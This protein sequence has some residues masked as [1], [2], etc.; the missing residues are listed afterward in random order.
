MVQWFSQPVFVSSTFADMQ[1]ER[2]HM[3]THVLPALE[4]R[5]Q[6]QRR[7]VEWVD[8]RLGVA[9]ASLAEGEAREMHVL[10]VC[11]AEVRRC[12]PF[13]IVLLGDRYGWVPPEDRMMAA[14][15]EEGFGED[16]LG[17]SVTDLEIQFGILDDPVQQPRSFVYLREPLAYGTMPPATAALYSE[18]Y[19]DDDGAADRAHRL[20]CLK[21][22]I[23]TQMP[24]R[25]RRYQANWDNEAG[26]VTGL[27]AWGRMV[28]D[29]IVAELEKDAAGTETED[30]LTWQD[31]ERIAR[32][33]FIADRARNF[34][35]RDALLADLEAHAFSPVDEEAG[36]G[37][38]LTGEA[39]AGKS[40]VFAALH[41]RLQQS[42]DVFL[43]SHAA[44]ASPQ[45][46]SVNSMLLRWIDELA[47]ELGVD[48]ELPENPSPDDIEASFASLLGRV[49]LQRRVVVLIDALDQFEPTTR[50]RQVAWLPRLWSNNARLI[51]TAIPGDATAALAERPHIKKTSLAPLVEGEAR[52]IIT[53]ICD[54]YHRTFE[55][56]VIEA[57]IAKQGLDGP[58]WGNTLWLVL[59]VEE[60]NLIDADDF[61][62]ARGTYTGAPAEQLRALM[63]DRVAGL[64]DNIQGLYLDSFEHAE[65]LFDAFD[66]R[67]F[68]GAIAVSRGGWRE[69][70]F[71]NLMPRL[72]GVPW[73]ELQFATLR[74]LFRGQVKQRGLLAQWTFTHTQMGKAAFEYLQRQEVTPAEIHTEIA[75]HLFS[76][77]NDDP[78]RETET[79]VHLL[80]SQDLVRAAAFYG[81]EDLT[82]GE[83]IG[84]T[85]VLAEAILADG[86][87]EDGQGVTQT[88]ALLEA[89]PSDDTKG[90]IAQRLI[91]DVSDAIENTSRLGVRYKLC[92]AA[93]RALAGLA[94][95]DPSNAGWQRDLS[96]SHI[97]IGDVLSAQGNL[98][99]ALESC[100]SS[101]E[102]AAGLAQSDPSNAGWQR[103]LSVLHNKIGD[104]LSAQ[105][106][107]SEAL[108][109]YRSSMEIAAGLAQSDPSNA[110]WQ[111][112]LVVSHFN[113]ARMLEAMEEPEA[114]LAAFRTGREILE[115]LAEDT[116]VERWA[117][118]LASFDS[119]I[120][121]LSSGDA[122]VE[123]ADGSGSA[124]SMPLTSVLKEFLNEQDWQDEIDVNEEHT[125]AQLRTSFE[126]DGQSYAAF[127]EVNESVETVA[128]YLYTPINVAPARRG[129]IALLLN[130][131]NCQLGLGRFAT[132][133]DD[134]PR[135]VQW[136][137]AIDVEGSTLSSAQIVVL[138]SAGINA[139]Q[140]YASAISAVALTEVSAQDVLEH[141]LSEIDSSQEFDE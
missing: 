60:L 66:T 64:S 100:R 3:R 80:G 105:G 32:D 35:G 91:Y 61:E 98:S 127:I 72:S 139:C 130:E 47:E 117:N 44:G 115:P 125:H 92:A 65:E 27:E 25:V 69:S 121:R 110:G 15:R 22:E 83:A 99:E 45:S 101:M 76:L 77:P 1:A 17:R 90:L 53:A 85:S 31:V 6:S 48:P 62:H 20:E 124:V 122:V 56:E 41:D 112:D 102:I 40:A 111:V 95:S 106:N 108:E 84:A 74:R 138:V 16:V 2:D 55:P 132:A 87:D 137:G 11:L 13:L 49:G 7:H 135:P 19:A 14:A 103:D 59:A 34:I 67:A 50:G 26:E 123:N 8:L 93:Q 113:R 82:E 96:V 107:L 140:N 86:G 33:D 30:E 119:A 18:A 136:C 39:G 78:L 38:Y 129:E 63:L 12:R 5:L 94:Q 120:H 10:K 58:A 4:E 97:K 71:I 73:D 141:A 68:L 36:W 9:T 21:S 52:E 134:E 131:I 42:A 79:M 118:M 81:D 24:E 46:P 128:V 88:I 43:L 75:D 126:I 89:A 51:A 54:R 29:D 109:S 114:A 104:V 116:A 28:V 37:L 23:T 57:L 133:H 70:D